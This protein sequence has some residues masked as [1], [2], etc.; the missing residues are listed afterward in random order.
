MTIDIIIDEEALQ[1]CLSEIFIDEISTNEWMK[2]IDQHLC[3][4]STTPNN[5]TLDIAL[6][7]N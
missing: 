7:E 6:M 4:L 5:C 2:V 1:K 3:Y